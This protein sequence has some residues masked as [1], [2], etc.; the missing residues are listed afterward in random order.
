M[1]SVLIVDTPSASEELTTLD[2][3]KSELGIAPDDTRNDARLANFITQASAVCRDYCSTTFGA[4]SY[5]E[6]FYG[7]TKSDRLVSQRRPL[8][9]LISVSVGQA[10]YSGP[11][12]EHWDTSSPRTELVEGIDYVAEMDTGIIQLLS[13]GGGWVMPA[14]VYTAGY[15]LLDGLPPSIE[16]ACI[17]LIKNYHFAS[18]RDPAM[19]Q[20]NIPGV[21]ERRW[22]ATS[23][24][25]VA[26]VPK[27]VADLLRPYVWFGFT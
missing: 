13:P 26:G 15:E 16:R 14:L 21:A 11:R 4:A 12:V 22:S 10:D 18:S 17:E 2:T 19:T 23:D 1:H 7:S 5:T 6:T 3:V 27:Y 24:S 25:T 8:I 9:E 20:E